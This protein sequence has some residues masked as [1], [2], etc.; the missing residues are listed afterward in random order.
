[1]TAPLDRTVTAAIRAGCAWSVRHDQPRAWREVARMTGVIMRAAGPGNGPVTPTELIACLR[2][3]LGSWLPGAAA[4][5]S[6]AALVVLDDSG[7]L[8]DATY[9]VG[10]DYTVELLVDQEDPGEGWL[11][12][13]RVHRAEQIERAAFYALRRGSD[14]DYTRGRRF[15]VEYPAGERNEVLAR[16]TDLG[17]PPLVSFTPIPDDRQHRGWWWAC[18]LCR[19]PMRI[20]SGHMSCSFPRHRAAYALLSADGRIPRLQ[21]LEGA[22][23][24]VQRQLVEGAVCVDESVWRYIVVPGVVEVR[25]CDRLGRIPGIGTLLY[26]FKDRYDIQVQPDDGDWECTLDVKDFAS[27]RS[28]ANKLIEKPVA[29]KT[30]VL[31]QYRSGQVM[32]LRRLLP[33]MAV[34]TESGICAKVRRLGGTS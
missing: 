31:P 6:L 21:P 25:L 19:W 32:E 15:L 27:A 11:P 14:D 4:D 7:R 24:R 34:M 23:Q 13:W 9:E 8:S 18:P 33:G 29:A 28:L 30:L 12:S 3:P 2:R 16:Q 26:P 22:P 10:C 17:L 20:R 1:M 5:E